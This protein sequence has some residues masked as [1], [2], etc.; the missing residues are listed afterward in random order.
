MR[1]PVVV[2]ID[3]ASVATRRLGVRQVAVRVDAQRQRA[4]G[5]ERVRVGDGVVVRASAVEPGG[6]GERAGRRG[7]TAGGAR[8]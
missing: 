6:A 1:E 2:A 8:R 3:G 5:R 4:R 7:A